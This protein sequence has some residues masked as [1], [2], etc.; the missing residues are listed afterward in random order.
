MDR[1]TK[2]HSKGT[3][4][5][6]ISGYRKVFGCKRNCLRE[7][8]AYQY[9]FQKM[10]LG[11]GRVFGQ[12]NITFKNLALILAVKALFSKMLNKLFSSFLDIL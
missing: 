7:T 5:I 4:L 1:R 2:S 11:E 8:F 6:Q 3:Y 12:K 10:N 9:A